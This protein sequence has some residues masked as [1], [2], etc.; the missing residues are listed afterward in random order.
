[1]LLYKIKTPNCSSVE[2]KLSI[3]GADR[4]HNFKVCK[5]KSFT[6]WKP[7]NSRWNCGFCPPN[8]LS[9]EEL[10][11]RCDTEIG[12]GVLCEIFLDLGL[13]MVNHLQPEEGALCYKV[14]EMSFTE[15]FM[16]S[17]RME[18]L[19]WIPVNTSWQKKKNSQTKKDPK[20]GCVA[21]YLDYYYFF[22]K[23]MRLYLGRGKKKKKEKE[24]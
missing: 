8:L 1:M 11:Q 24:I 22:F 20:G 10:L 21:A 12:V 17:C 19:P 14:R 6:S 5:Q 3:S 9:F 18:I 16:Y 2:S 7:F 23:F 15:Y 13:K 4:V